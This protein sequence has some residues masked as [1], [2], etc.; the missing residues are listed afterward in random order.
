MEADIAE[1]QKEMGG[2]MRGLLVVLTICIAFTGLGQGVKLGV[3]LGHPE[4]SI[5]RIESSNDDRFLIVGS[6]TG[7]VKLFD[8]ETGK[9]LKSFKDHLSPIRGIFF[10]ESGNYFVSYCEEGK[11]IIYSVTSLD[12][13]L[14]KQGQK[15]NQ[16]DCMMV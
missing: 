6:R 7:S 11:V 8:I 9:L 16:A 14:T 3:P 15:S 13:V 10:T 4:F 2:S 1:G 12:K 5:T